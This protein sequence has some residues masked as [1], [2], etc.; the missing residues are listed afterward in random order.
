MKKKNISDATWGKKSNRPGHFGGEK[1][2]P[3]V[4]RAYLGRRK[5]AAFSD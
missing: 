4:Q 2:K 1:E 3:G 5:K